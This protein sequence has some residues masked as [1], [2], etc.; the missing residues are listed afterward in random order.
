[1][2]T[3]ALTQNEQEKVDS[4]LPMLKVKMMARQ[5]TCN[6]HLEAIL[7]DADVSMRRGVYNLLKPH[8][9]FK[10]KSFLCMKFGKM[11]KVGARKIELK[12]VIVMDACQI[13]VVKKAEDAQ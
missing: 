8:L 10:A 9:R 12:P 7:R 3:L 1:M 6:D 11:K 5:I 2:E 4:I 13:T